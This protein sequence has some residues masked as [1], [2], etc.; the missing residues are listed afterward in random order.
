[1]ELKNKND[2][3]NFITTIRRLGMRIDDIAQK[4]R[5]QIVPVKFGDDGKLMV[6]E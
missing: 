4:T 6:A 5:N 1:M 3:N 2:L